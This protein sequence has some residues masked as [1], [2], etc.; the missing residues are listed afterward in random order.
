MINTA[1]FVRVDDAEREKEACY[2]DNTRGPQLLAEACHKKGIR[3]ISFSSDLVFDGLKS[4]AYVE[5]DPVNPLNVY[6]STKAE[7]EE[8]VRLACPSALMIRT[9]A[10]FGPWDEYNF[11]SYVRKSLSQY[12]PINVANNILISPTYVPDLVH[13]SLD[14]LI[15]EVEGIWHLANKGQISWSELAHEVASNFDLDRGLIQSLTNEE[16]NY[17]APRPD[18]S[19]LSS[20]RGQLLPGL[21]EALGRYFQGQKR[22]ER[23]VA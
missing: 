19:V 1:G 18:N 5:S 2:R 23:K 4:G 10:F 9:S 21:E 13:A 16:M 8:L 22:T 6:G 14:L 17:P 20:E 15:D 3:L 11:L 7:A 12:Q